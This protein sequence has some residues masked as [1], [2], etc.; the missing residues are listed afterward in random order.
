MEV[1]SDHLSCRLSRDG[2]NGGLGGL[3]TLPTHARISETIRGRTWN[4]RARTKVREREEKEGVATEVS[5][6][7]SPRAPRVEQAHARDPEPRGKRH[8][9]RVR[10][11]IASG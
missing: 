3:L 11:N 6:I 5:E 7:S 1:T 9:V 4:Q 10:R 8:E 2:G